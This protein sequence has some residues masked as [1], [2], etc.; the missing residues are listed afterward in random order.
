LKFC[1]EKKKG[2]KKKNEKTKKQKNKKKVRGKNDV[3]V[4]NVV[5]AQHTKE[6]CSMY[7]LGTS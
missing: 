6:Q 5:V 2:K 4:A 1:Q 3:N 7:K